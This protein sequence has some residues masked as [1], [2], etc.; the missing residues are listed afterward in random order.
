M[1]DEGINYAMKLLECGV[2]TEL[3][4]YPGTFHGSSL[5]VGA[6]VS[7]RAGKEMMEALARGLGL[8]D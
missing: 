2:S 8:N 1:R 3:H 6:K 4:A 7:Q 5:V